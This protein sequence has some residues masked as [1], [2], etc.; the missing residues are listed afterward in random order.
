MGQRL[1]VRRVPIGLGSSQ[2]RRSPFS[3]SSASKL[4]LPGG[5]VAQI[6]S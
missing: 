2:I 3:S 6:A 4:T 5:S 1:R